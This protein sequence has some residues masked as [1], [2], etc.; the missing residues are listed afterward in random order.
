MMEWEKVEAMND[1]V[2]NRLNQ[3]SEIVGVV[4]RH[5]KRE[6]SAELAMHEIEMLITR[7]NR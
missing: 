4:L 6:M 1:M 3:L 5:A 7:E 2:N